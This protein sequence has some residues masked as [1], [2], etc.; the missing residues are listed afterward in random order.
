MLKNRSGKDPV[1]TAD[2]TE[3]LSGFIQILS[4]IY[5]LYLCFFPTDSY[6]ARV[7]AEK[8]ECA[9]CHV[10]WMADFKREDVVTLIPYEPRPMQETGR[11][12]VVSTERMCFS[13]HDGFVLDSRFFWEEKGHSHPVGI[14]PSDRVRIPTEEGKTIFPLND[15]GK[16]YCGTCHSAHGVEWGN[17]ISPVFLRIPNVDSSICSTCHID[18][19][20]ETNGHLNHPLL[21]KVPKDGKRLQ[22]DGAKF[23]KDDK[24][25]C[26]SC[27]RVHGSKEKK[28]LVKNNDR[29]QLCGTCHSDKARNGTNSGNGHTH[30]INVVPK[31]AKIPEDFASA[32]S[33]FGPNKEVICQT[34][35]AVHI[36]PSGKLLVLEQEQLKEGICLKCHDN[37]R[38]VLKYGHNLLAKSD[39]TTPRE[40]IPSKNLG[41]CGTCHNIHG[42]N[43]PKMWARTLAP[44]GN[45]VA[46]LCLSCHKQGGAAEK[47]TVGKYSHPVG[48]TLPSGVK[49]GKLPLFTGSGAKT[50]SSKYGLVTC[51]TCHD[52]HGPASRLKPQTSAREKRGG[53][54]KYLRIGEGNL[55]L[56]CK[57]CHEDKWSITKTKHDLFPEKR[58]SQSLGVCSNCHQV[59]N[60]KGPRMWARDGDFNKRDLG[61]L[62]KNCHVKDGVAKKKTVGG[63]S[64]PLGVSVEKA[65][66]KVSPKGWI[67]EGDKKPKPAV[68][69]LYDAH[70]KKQHNTE[71]D[72]G[73][74]TC[75]DPHQWNPGTSADAGGE[76]EGDARNSF[77]RISAAPDGELCIICHRSKSTVRQTDHDL[78]VTVPQADNALGEGLTQ[79]GVCGQCHA[80]HNAVQDFVIWGRP[81]GPGR[82]APEMLCR[83]CHLEG[84]IAQK[85]VPEKAEHP[86]YVLAWD[87]DMRDPEM[88]SI[89]NLP[90]FR[91]DGR[92]A[93]LGY[94]SCP[95]CHNVHQWSARKPGVEGSGKNEEGDVFNSFLRMKS[96]EDVLCA[97]CHGLD[98]IFRYKYFHGTSFNKDN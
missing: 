21:E 52:V 15:D 51:P 74:A 95:T 65:G 82:D 73:C 43:G 16:V 34:C 44:G 68:L 86:G 67:G 14:V 25:I 10:A 81:L 1:A 30:P 64:H 94:I 40:K 45:A 53:E 93:M 58:N 36:A 47:H 46:D 22:S 7:V 97:D 13:C 59:H 57:K 37:K 69:P 4:T 70:G 9:T 49:P 35:H 48:A 5:I 56:L 83:S 2:R 12:D 75:H 63:H 79:S 3:S 31:E 96:T 28:L 42:G 92:R 55:T 84:E 76:E 24:V 85:K 41:V 26:Q 23:G 71:G 88:R 6:A 77:L 39:Q 98:A 91:D 17:K 20:G 19:K 38:T 8:R 33:K 90:V 61:T 18:R 72:V 29:S 11:Q 78:S 32:G 87:G 60:G 54:G 50:H 80:V 66:I 89:T 27:H 62:C